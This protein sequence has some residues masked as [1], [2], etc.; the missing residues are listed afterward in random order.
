M[1]V[2][3]VLDELINESLE[4][5][6]KAILQL[7][8]GRTPLARVGALATAAVRQPPPSAATSLPVAVLQPP[9]SAN[10]Q[11]SPLATRCS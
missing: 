9:P 2:V 1:E 8:A 10:V 7:P 4:R 11:P 6:E 3:R 5:A